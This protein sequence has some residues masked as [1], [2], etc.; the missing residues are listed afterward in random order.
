MRQK[1][2]VGRYEEY[3]LDFWKPVSLF[4]HCL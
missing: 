3:M 1:T 4:W 2:A